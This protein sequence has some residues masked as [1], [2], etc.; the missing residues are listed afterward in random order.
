MQRITPDSVAFANAFTF[1]EAAF[2]RVRIE[3]LT[4]V[5]SAP[6]DMPSAARRPVRSSA[7]PRWLSEF[8]RQGAGQRV[9]RHSEAI[10]KV[11]A[12]RQPCGCFS[13]L[14]EEFV[15]GQRFSEFTA[16]AP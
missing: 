10:D 8:P 14:Y 13:N 16:A 15:S 11:L 12:N 5:V 9:G 2:T 3:G 1:L 4:A 6:T 7:L